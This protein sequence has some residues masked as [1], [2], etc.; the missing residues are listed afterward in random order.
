MAISTRFPAR[1]T[2]ALFKCGARVPNEDGVPDFQGQEKVIEQD[3]GQWIA[4]N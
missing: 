2:K 1:P 4:A 3:P